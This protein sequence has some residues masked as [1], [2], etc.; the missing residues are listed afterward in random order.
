MSCELVAYEPVAAHLAE[1]YVRTPLPANEEDRLQTLHTL[2]QTTDDDPV[3]ASL[4]KLLCSLLKMPAAGARPPLPQP[5][6]A[7]VVAKAPRHPSQTL[8]PEPLFGMH[9]HVRL[10]HQ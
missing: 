5:C 6:I 1:D 2:V 8:W 7:P 9:H 10:A 3:L 4:C